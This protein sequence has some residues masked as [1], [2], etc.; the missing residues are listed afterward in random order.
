MVARFFREHK[1]AADTLGKVIR[2]RRAL[3]SSTPA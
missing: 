1:H 3:D 2:E